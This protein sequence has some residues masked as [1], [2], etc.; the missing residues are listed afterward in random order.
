MAARR[1]L[2]VPFLA[3]AVTLA[4]AGCSTSTGDGDDAGTGGSG[5]GGSGA[6]GDDGAAGGLPER[7]ECPMGFIPGDGR[8]PADS[9]DC[10]EV[11]CA[12][13]VV[14]TC[15]ADSTSCPEGTIAFTE[16]P[17]GATC[18]DQGDLFCAEI[19]PCSSSAGGISGGACEEIGALC[20]GVAEHECDPP[21]FECVD[22]VW[23]TE[24]TEV[25]P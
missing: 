17:E 9:L 13:G 16:C 21:I 4:L 14:S 5:Q 24:G 22:H 3:L 6:G 20:D 8:C 1:P 15:T 2:I 12:G 7:C 18:E 19:V 11:E 10:H 23:T 25:C